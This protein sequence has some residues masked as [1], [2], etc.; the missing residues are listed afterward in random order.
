PSDPADLDRSLPARRFPRVHRARALA[1]GS[2]P[3]LVLPDRVLAT[4]RRARERA[5]DRELRR[6]GPRPS[7]GHYALG[8]VRRRE[9][10]HDRLVENTLVRSEP[11]TNVLPVG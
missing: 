2:A 10:P 6:L 11:G 3:A 4:A 8:I 1:R 9:D 7:D 5:R